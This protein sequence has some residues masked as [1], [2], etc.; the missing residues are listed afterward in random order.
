[1]YLSS[2]M[3]DT[4]RR[5]KLYVLNDER[6]WDDR[7]TGHVS[8]CL[9]DRLNG[10]CLLVCSETDGSIL[11]ES[12]IQPDTAY[13]KQ[14]E[15]LIVWSENDNYD[16]ALSFQERAGCDDI[17]EII[18][19][20]QGKDPSVDITQDVVDESEE[21]R[22]E[23]LP[24]AATPIELP[25]C[26]ISKL[27]EITEL[28]SSALQSPIKREKL[29]IAIEKENYIR[30]LIELFCICED[31]DNNTECLHYLY[32]IMKNTIL[33]NKTSLLE[34][35]FSDELIYD[36]VGCLEHDPN[37]T[38][39][40]RHREYL[41]SKANFHEVIP[42]T[43]R[44]LLNKIHQTYRV[45]YIQDVILPTPSVFE[46]NMLSTL[47]SFVFFN[48]VDIVDMIQD[49][50][51][52]LPE[53]FAQL[54]SESTENHRR[55]DLVLFLKE[56]C[57]F[58][59]NSQ[60]R[61]GFFKTLSSLG[62]LPALEVVLGMDDS[63]VRQAAIDIFSLVVGFNASMVREFIMHEGSSSEDDVLLINLVIE[64]MICDTDPDLG[65]ALQLM[66]ILKMLVD[67]ENMMATGVKT[68]KTE[69]LTFFYKHCMHV[70]TAPLLANTIDDK[71]SKDDYQTSQ[72]LSLILELLTFAVEHHTYH[73]KNYIINKDLL[74][75]ILV[76]LRSSHHFLVLCA[77]RFFRKVVAMRDDFY[78]RYIVKGNLFEPLVSL[79]NVN[80]SKYNLLNSALIELFE[81]IRIEGI[82]MLLTHIVEK[83]G[84]ELKGVDYV[85]TF[86]GLSVKYEQFM[87]RINTR[88]NLDNLRHASILQNTR[89]RRDAR[90][91][92]EEEELW[93]DQDEDGEDAEA[94]VPVVD[95]AFRSAKICG[96][97]IDDVEDTGRI[98]GN[99]KENQLL[100]RS[101]PLNASNGRPDTPLRPS[102]GNNPNKRAAP[103]TNNRPSSP[104]PVSSNTST[105][106][107]IKKM[108]DTEL[109]NNIG[110]SAEVKKVSPASELK[111]NSAAKQGGLVGLVDYPDEDSDED[112]DAD[113][114]PPLKRARLI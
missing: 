3:S 6:Q 108:A 63:E 113:E 59:Q 51:K 71:P 68:E 55:R 83:H 100:N 73:I 35:L 82:K 14:Q 87:D 20:V 76:L 37:A 74:R 44:N 49:D 69:F 2:K 97:V 38:D 95:S 104:I 50:E 99:K 42:I 22:F 13:Q 110:G 16:L 103:L 107:T 47:S 34:I 24:E 79:F 64:Q 85:A 26:E 30:K 32:E 98:I 75:R 62:I 106:P 8:S 60:N 15:T 11:L 17:W 27:E 105:S 109:A 67:P 1:M 65:S 12:K 19:Q 81:F 36:V 5:V 90:D 94:V 25:P 86:K 72:L 31:L 84:E 102:P 46:E 88:P 56:F 57:C 58:A 23:E 53:L 96:D 66:N 39:C 52:F 89:F 10:M 61:E 92:D 101:E 111:A 114:H 77:V 7:G 70:L 93:F 78:N 21:D 54:I 9:V 41:N 40:R 29:A 18:C 33:L 28:F 45:Q 48:K 43:N 112:E 80:R 4:R 91:L